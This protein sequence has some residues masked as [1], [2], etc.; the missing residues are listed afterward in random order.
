M[1]LISRVNKINNDDGIPLNYIRITSRLN[2]PKIDKYELSEVDYIFLQA[3]E[4]KYTYG[5]RKALSV[6]LLEKV[7][8]EL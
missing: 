5:G 2:L 1:E 4:N 3:N 7:I 8:V 6:E